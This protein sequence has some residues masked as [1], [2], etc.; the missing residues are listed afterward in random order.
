MAIYAV[1]YELHAPDN[2]YYE[3][4]QELKAFGGYSKRFDSFWLIDTSH[5]TSDIRNNLTK[6]I[7]RSDKLLVIKVQKDWAGYNINKDMVGWLAMHSQ[8][9]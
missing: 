5:S 1:T 9:F 8:N 4:Y 3:F 2:N 7:K 6:L